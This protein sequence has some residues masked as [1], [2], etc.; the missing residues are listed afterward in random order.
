V[1]SWATSTDYEVGMVT[2]T[3]MDTVDSNL[4]AIFTPYL[5]AKKVIKVVI[6]EPEF[7]FVNRTILSLN[8]TSIVSDPSLC[9]SEVYCWDKVCSQKGL[10]TYDK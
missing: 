8:N 2:Q 5:V 1:A 7:S 10:I 3:D 6:G 4:T 9:T